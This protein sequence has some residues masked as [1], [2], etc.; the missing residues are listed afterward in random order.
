MNVMNILNGKIYNIII[1]F[2][3]ISDIILLTWALFFNVGI[4]IYTYLVYFDLIVCL[5]LIPDFSYHLWKS[6]NKRRFLRNNWFDM[7]GMIPIIIF[8]PHV[9]AASSVIRYIRLFTLI[10]ILGLFKN[11]LTRIER[12]LRKT[13]L[14]YGFITLIL[15]LASGTI[16]FYFLE[17]GANNHVENIY[18]ALWYVIISITTVGYGDI[19]PVTPGGKLVSVVI[20]VSG[21]VFFGFLTATLSSW[22]TKRDEEQAEVKLD[23]IESLILNMKNEMEISKL[24]MKTEIENLK[25][26]IEKNKKM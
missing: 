21:I 25:E 8:A 17:V 6:E 5:I 1:T 2:L 23:K 3:V 18:D 7:F 16:I 19:S 24:E 15:I 4:Q 11:D 13:N 9:A 12:F 26:L 22:F 10:R 20:I 14:D